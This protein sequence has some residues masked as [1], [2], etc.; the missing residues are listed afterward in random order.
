MKK[1][2]AQCNLYEKLDENTIIPFGKLFTIPDPIK[3]IG[4]ILICPI[5]VY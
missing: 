5:P 3:K 1:K 4:A 2:T